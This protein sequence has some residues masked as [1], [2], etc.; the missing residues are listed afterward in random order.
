MDERISDELSNKS[1]V[2]IKYIPLCEQNGPCPQCNEP[3]AFRVINFDSRTIGV[4]CAV[5]GRFTISKAQLDDA[6]A[7]KKADDEGAALLQKG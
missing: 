3:A 1:V 2:T 6:R 5:C 4:N 7:Q